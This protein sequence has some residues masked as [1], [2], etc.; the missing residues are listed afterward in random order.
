[1]DGGGIT[2]QLGQLAR[3]EWDHGHLRLNSSPGQPDL[4][5]DRIDA[6]A[7]L[8]RA[9]E[10]RQQLFDEVYAIKGLLGMT[11]REKVHLSHLE[12]LGIIRGS[13]LDDIRRLR[14]A[15]E[16]RSEVAPDRQ[17]CLLYQ[18]ATWYFLRSTEV[19]A[20]R[21]PDIFE[22]IRRADLGNLE[23]V[24]IEMGPPSWSAK[25][26]SELLSPEFV[27][28]CKRDSWI[29]IKLANY[30]ILTIPDNTVSIWGSISERDWVLEAAKI[31]FSC[32]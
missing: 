17:Q 23:R 30:G 11:R 19:Y 2:S 16:H 6:I 8:W 9:V 29:P 20:R 21:V 31:Y 24:E 27:S 5:Q 13:V 25:I 12:Q 18:D 4:E 22:L 10:R 14:N 32:V 15:I 7:A 3:R 26:T 28:I 1:L